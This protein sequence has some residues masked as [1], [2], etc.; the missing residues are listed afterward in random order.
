MPNAIHDAVLFIDI[1]VILY[2][3]IERSDIS[4]IISFIILNIPN[5]PELNPKISNLFENSA[6]F[7]LF[8]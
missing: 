7:T 6:L 2:S 4:S 3:D 5:T 1:E 8:C